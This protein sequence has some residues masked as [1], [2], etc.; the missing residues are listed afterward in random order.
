MSTAIA[1]ASSEPPRGRK[2]AERG[3][4]GAT[5]SRRRRE[6]STPL[7]DAPALVSLT[8]PRLPDRAAR[9][10]PGA[11][12]LPPAPARCPRSREHV[13][14]AP[15]PGAVTLSLLSDA[16]GGDGITRRVA[17]SAPGGVRQGETPAPEPLRPLARAARPPWRASG[18]RR[19]E[20]GASAT[21]FL[22][23][24][25]CPERPMLSTWPRKGFFHDERFQDGLRP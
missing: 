10:L 6:R 9:G 20:G 14:A 18:A 19:R 16:R 21:Q 7:S 15:T 25:E 22:P 4:R 13:S 23:F 24:L 5:C 17:R 8:P 11:G 12:R 2:G 3:Y 1:T